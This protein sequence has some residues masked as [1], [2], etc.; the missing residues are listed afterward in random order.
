[1]KKES[2]LGSLVQV[3]NPKLAKQ[4]GQRVKLLCRS[5]EHGSEC[6]ENLFA[7]RI[8]KPFQAGDPGPFIY[9]EWLLKYA[10]SQTWRSA[11]VVATEFFRL[12]QPVE[13]LRLLQAFDTWKAYL[14]GER[15]DPG[16]S[17]HHLLVFRC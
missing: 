16:P 13:Y 15:D 5:C 7:K 3:V 10:V 2:A 11:L 1:M 4:Q 12:E 6:G 9:A 8:F 14:R 17:E